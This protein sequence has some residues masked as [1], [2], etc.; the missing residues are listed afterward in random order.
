[1]TLTQNP[2]GTY[3]CQ[4]CQFVFG[5]GMMAEL[6]DGFNTYHTRLHT[7]VIKNIPNK[8]KDIA[9]GER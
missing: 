1:M 2:D 5:K 9:Q 8:F 3:T 4:E 6:G 7:I